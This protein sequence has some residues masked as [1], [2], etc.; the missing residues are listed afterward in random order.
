MLKPLKFARC[1]TSFSLGASDLLFFELERSIRSVTTL[2]DLVWTTFVKFLFVIV[3]QHKSG[4]QRVG[5]ERN[6]A[7]YIPVFFFSKLLFIIVLIINCINFYHEE[8]RYLDIFQRRLHK[9]KQTVMNLLRVFTHVLNVCV[10]VS[11]SSHFCVCVPQTCLFSCVP[12]LCSSALPCLSHI[13][14]CC[15]Q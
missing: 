11:G 13:C 10:S 8:F 2:F 12:C 9:K 1:S 7:E 14:C 4:L 15:V 6:K 5:V 3:E